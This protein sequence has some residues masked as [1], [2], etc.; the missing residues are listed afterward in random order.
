MSVGSK[1]QLVAV[2]FPQRLNSD[3][4]PSLLR[5]EETPVLRNVMPRSL[6]TELRPRNGLT[7]V[8]TWRA[9]TDAWGAGEVFKD[10]PASWIPYH[11]IFSPD[12]RYLLVGTVKQAGANSPNWSP[13][14]TPT[15]TVPGT[16]LYS[17]SG[18]GGYVGL[19]V[20]TGTLTYDNDWI[21]G[22]LTNVQMWGQPVY[23]DGCVLWQNAADVAGNSPLTKYYHSGQ[24]AY[25]YMITGVSSVHAW[26]G[27]LSASI[28]IVSSYDRTAT[29]SNATTAV[30]LGSSVAESMK[31]WLIYPR[32][33]PGTAGQPNPAYRWLYKVKSHTAAGTAMTL[34]RPY[35]LGETTT[36]VPNLAACDT[37]TLQ[38]G[39]VFGAIP[40]GVTLAVFNDRVFSARGTVSTTL[41]TGA[42]QTYPSPVGEYGGYYGN[43]LFWSKPGNFNRWPD[44]NFA[45]VD[46]DADDPITGLYTLGDSLI[47]FKSTKMFRMTG[48]DEDSFQIDKISEVV[49]CPYPMGMVSYEGTLFFANQEGVW[50]YNGDSLQSITAPDGSHGISKL[51]ASR[52]WSRAQGMSKEYF[53]PTMAV[54][55]DGHLLVVCHYPLATDQYNDHFVYDTKSGSWATWG[56]NT[57]TANPIRVVTAPNG[58][59]YGIHRWFVSELTDLFNPSVLSPRYDSYPALATGTT[60]KESV[61]P[62]AEVWFNATSGM[63]VRLREMQ[64]DHKVHYT[65]SDST[66]SYSPWTIKLATDPDLTLGSTEH[67]VQARWISDSGYDYT[68]PLHYSDRFPETFQREAQTI[69]VRLTGDTYPD[70]NERIRDWSLYGIKLTLDPT[71]QLGVD[72]STT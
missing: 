31:G 56:M 22:S 1:S 33:T 8:V 54:T 18:T 48:Y 35:G 72:N 64:V 34:E 70:A 4:P 24:A 63:T 71:R 12:S 20:T 37:R 3:T 21:N 26:G 51:W 13:Y 32:G 57:A 38:S 49:G 11:A 36:N 50:A 67:S 28:G 17:T 23:Y 60:T 9:A 58:K 52:P 15:A 7:S 16:T 44:Q 19:D 10:A 25:S 30:T 62:E 29:V 42:P 6:P 69:R 41:T 39:D 27:T 14:Y 5:P 45:L 61:A 65:Y 59:V 40:G 47:I 2:P 55:P 68:R 53:W 46:Q 43:A 66:P